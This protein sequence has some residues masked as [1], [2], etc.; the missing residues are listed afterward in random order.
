MKDAVQEDGP[1]TGFDEKDALY[2][3]VLNKVKQMSTD[4]LFASMV[5]TGIYTKSGKLTKEYGGRAK[6]QK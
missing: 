4:E 5:A 3:R 2:A 6:A 1:V